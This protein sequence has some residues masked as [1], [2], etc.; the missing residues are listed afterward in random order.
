MVHNLS[1]QQSIVN[2]F[3]AQLRDAEYQKSRNLFRNNLRRLGQ[4]FAYEIGKRVDYAAQSIQSPLGSL[5]VPVI[6]DRIVLATVLRAG[7]PMYEG[8]LSFFDDADSAF[9]ASYR[10]HHGDGSLEINMEYMTCP[11]MGGTVL[12]L[13]DPMIATG[14]SISSALDA[15]IRLG[16]PKKIHIV[17]AVASKAGIDHISRL[18]PE[19]DIWAAAID[20]ELT[21][22]AYIVP[23]LGDAGDLAFG[24]KS[25]S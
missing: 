13:A 15:V 25:Q 22:K 17:C 23:G 20:E 21:A 14:K 1:E 10:K 18:Y 6:S 12:I 5:D 16:V 3:M 4:I 9:I 7:L 8:L 2:H 11:A 24:S 19:A